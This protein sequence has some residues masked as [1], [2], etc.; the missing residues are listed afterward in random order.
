MPI[1]QSPFGFFTP[2]NFVASVQVESDASYGSALYA[3]TKNDVALVENTKALADAVGALLKRAKSEAVRRP[4]VWRTMGGERLPNDLRKLVRAIVSCGQTSFEHAIFV[5]E[6]KDSLGTENK[7]M[8]ELGDYFTLLGTASP[9]GRA[10]ARHENRMKIAMRAVDAR[11]IELN[12]KKE[13][14]K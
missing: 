11:I 3:A 1:T 9:V 14:E 12:Q 5:V 7:I 13:K 8:L 6:W 4:V 10:R 2:M